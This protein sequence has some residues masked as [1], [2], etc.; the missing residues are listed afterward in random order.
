[1]LG[2][3]EFL[4]G[5]L[6][7][8][9]PDR[10]A[11][12]RREVFL[13]APGK[14]TA[15]MAYAYYTRARGGQMMSIE[16]RWSRSDTIDVS[17]YRFSSDY[18]RSWSAPVERPTGEKRPEGMLRRH[19]RGGWV[20]PGT[21]RCLEFWLEGTLPTD[22][23]LE[24][25]RQ[26][27]IF[28]T[29]SEGDPRR[30]HGVQQVIHQGAEYDA[31]HPLPGVYTGKNCAMLGDQTSQPL[32]TRDG[33]ILVPVEISPLAPDGTLYNPG[34]GYTYHDSAV[35]HGRWKGGRIEWEMSD[36]VQGDPQR[37]TRGMVEHYR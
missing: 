17:Y 18:G 31:R 26:W 2:R 27:N 5:G 34:G 23:P 8:A 16:Q 3:R 10:G 1:M 37:T 13:P 4:S 9:L 14:G 32:G 30:H 28:Y 21:G 7:A 29:V 25:L 33:R 22:D 19:L 24:G 15:V 12:I 20:D 36:R 11:G 35:L 6:A